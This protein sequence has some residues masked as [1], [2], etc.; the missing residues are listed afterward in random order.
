SRTGFYLLGLIIEDRLERSYARVLKE[1]LLQPLELKSTRLDEEVQP[2]R[3]STHPYGPYGYNAYFWSNGLER[4]LPVGFDYHGLHWS[5]AVLS[6]I[7]SDRARWAL[8]H[9]GTVLV[10]SP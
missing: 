1:E 8:P 6:P 7:A 2:L 4:D 10:L 9:W 5:S 3:Y